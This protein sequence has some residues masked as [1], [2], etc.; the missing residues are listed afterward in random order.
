M[1]G[2]TRWRMYE[3]LRVMG[4]R[5]MVSNGMLVPLAW[6]AKYSVEDGSE[7]KH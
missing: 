2:R 5:T 6:S 4:K 7:N 3:A 1:E